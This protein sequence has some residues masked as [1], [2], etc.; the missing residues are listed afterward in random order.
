MEKASEQKERDDLY[1]TVTY[2]TL[3]D[4]NTAMRYLEMAYRKHVYWLIY[5]K[6]EPRLDP[7][8]SDP[9]FQ[10]LLKRMHLD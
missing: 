3:G 9:R 2:D 10:D 1:F 8:R 7:L 6:A 4:A 5:I